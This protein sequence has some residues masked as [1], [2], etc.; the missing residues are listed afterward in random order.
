LGMGVLFTTQ[1]S[2]GDGWQNSNQIERGKFHK[3]TDGVYT[4]AERRLF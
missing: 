1:R 3:A 2:S 4:P